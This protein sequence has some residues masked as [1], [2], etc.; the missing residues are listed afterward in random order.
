MTFFSLAI[1]L[2]SILKFYFFQ[3]FE[4]VAAP[5]SWAQL[6]SDQVQNKNNDNSSESY[7][8][9]RDYGIESSDDFLS[10]AD[11][12]GTAKVPFY[13]SDASLAILG[14][15][16]V[17]WY[18]LFFCFRSGLIF[19]FVFLLLALLCVLSAV[20]WSAPALH[21]AWATQPKTAFRRR[22]WTRL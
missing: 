2:C 7:S 5:S 3:A 12:R 10:A 18:F 6:S 22:Q 16:A 20:C 15:V 13:A 8:S 21:R 17:I 4:I 14:T 1:I 19:R 9:E 11:E